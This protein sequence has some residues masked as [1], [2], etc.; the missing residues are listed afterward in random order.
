MKPTL[1]E[2]LIAWIVNTALDVIERRSG[3]VLPNPPVAHKPEHPNG[4]WGERTDP[5]IPKRRNPE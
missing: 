3:A 2:R 1:L 4:E 5:A